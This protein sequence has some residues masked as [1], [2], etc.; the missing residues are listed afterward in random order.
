MR[1]KIVIAGAG[2]LDVLVQPAKEDIFL[3]GSVPADT[4]KISTGEMP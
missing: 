4:I 1:D 2:I 3:K